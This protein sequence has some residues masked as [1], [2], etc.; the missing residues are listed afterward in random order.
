VNRLPSKI[1]II[2]SR[3]RSDPSGVA[4]SDRDIRQASELFEAMIETRRQ[5]D[6]A[7]A[8]TEAWDRGSAWKLAL[9]R[10]LS[11][12]DVAT[13]AAVDAGL[14]EGIREL[15]ND[16]ADYGIEGEAL[17]HLSKL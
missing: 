4:K 12:L 1:R 6:L 3:R 5:A 13:R 7:T 16:P 9:R 15:G 10:G 14:A 11:R 8:F 17:P 2:A